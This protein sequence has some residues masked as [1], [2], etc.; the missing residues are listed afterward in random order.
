MI[1]TDPPAQYAMIGLMFI[2]PVSC[3]AAYRYFS[4]ND[5]EKLRSESFALRKIA[6]GMIEEKG[7]DIP[8]SEAS[9]EAIAN[10]E[11]QPKD[12]DQLGE[13]GK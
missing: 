6:L 5:P 12:V 1:F 13:N 9:V 11:Y 4:R 3:V 7:S 10:I 2:G 8:L